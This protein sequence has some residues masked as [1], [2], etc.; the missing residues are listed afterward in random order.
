MCK[1]L[2]NMGISFYIKFFTFF[3]YLSI[4]MC[5]Y[6]FS[7]GISFYI[8]FFTFFLYLLFLC[9]SIWSGCVIVCVIKLDTFMTSRDRKELSPNFTGFFYWKCRILEISFY[10]TFFTF[11][12]YFSFLCVS[13]YLV[14]EFPFSY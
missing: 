11:I 9:V 6:L 10:I 5:K 7:M 2:F 8:K 13:I 4:F 3:L 12:L 14:W 1:Y